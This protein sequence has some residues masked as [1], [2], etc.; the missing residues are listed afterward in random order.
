M[1]SRTG[2]V[3]REGEMI[4]IDGLEKERKRVE[5]EAIFHSSPPS[6]AK[7][8]EPVIGRDASR[9]QNKTHRWQSPPCKAFKN[10][11]AQ[12]DRQ[13]NLEEA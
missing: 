6:P 3:L 1:P 10:K 2:E 4:E 11:I 8:V 7:F 12:R 9:A 5:R 13:S